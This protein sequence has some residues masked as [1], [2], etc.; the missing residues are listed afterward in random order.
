MELDDICSTGLGLGLGC[1]V[2]Q[3]NFSESDQQKKKKLSL[4]HDHFFPSLTLG[5]SDDMYQSA[6]KIDASKVHGEWIDL[7]Q[8]AAS[9]SAVSSFSNSSVK[10][11]R[12]FCGEEVELERVSSRVSDEDEEG[13]PRKKLRLSKEQS[14]ILEEN[15]KEHSTLNPVHHLSLS[16]FYLTF[17]TYICIY[18]SSIL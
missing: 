13:S 11:E 16:L 3:E 4:K 18:I 15:F 10:K 12:D 6:T 17:Y 5:P 2:K 9:L 7:H 8:R 14:A 1:L